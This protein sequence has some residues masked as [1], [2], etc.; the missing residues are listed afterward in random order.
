MEL[1]LLKTQQG[2]FLPATEVEADKMRR[3]KVGG[4]VRAD[5]AQMR[6]AAFFRKWWALV[7]I[8]FDAWSEEPR[9]LEYKGEAVQ[10]TF[11]RFRKDLTVLAGYYIATYNILGE[12]CLEAKS[13]SF[14][15][16][17]EDE[18][19]GLFSKTIDVVLQKILPR[20]GYSEESLRNLVEQVLEFA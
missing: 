15:N 19:E 12:V 4:I 10:P 5:V 14:A 8:A 6:N 13:I 11:D 9:A 3:F 16:M 20:R 7:K 18:F 17:Q 1:L 2:A